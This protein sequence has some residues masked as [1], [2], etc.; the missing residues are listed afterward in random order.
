MARYRMLSDPFL[1]RFKS[2]MDAERR[3]PEGA[4]DTALTK[5]RKEGQMPYR[6]VPVAGCGGT[7]FLRERSNDLAFDEAP[8][9]ISDPAKK[10]LA[11]LKGKLS[12]ED[13]R[14]VEEL[15]NIEAGV[16]TDSEKK[17]DAM[18]EAA[19][20]RRGAQDSKRRQQVKHDAASS[21]N[22]AEFAARF[23]GAARIG[24]V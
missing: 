14:Q 2:F 16:E 23:P 12:A 11:F 18:Y 5:T 21:A 17:S 13:L 22:M 10:I 4:F 3:N 24:H 8:A 7:L 1:A 15:L 9:E 6:F 20:Q 19:E